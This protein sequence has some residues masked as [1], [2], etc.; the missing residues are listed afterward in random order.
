MK[1]NMNTYKGWEL[2]D[3]DR[4]TWAKQH[5][6]G[7][8]SFIG[9]MEISD[10]NDFVVQK[11]EY[12]ASDELEQDQW[13]VFMAVWEEGYGLIPYDYIDKEEWL[14]SLEVR[15]SDNIEL[16]IDKCLFWQ[17]FDNEDVCTIHGWEKACA[18]IKG[19]LDTY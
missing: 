6:D 9:L 7:H 19:L 18:K 5:E 15:C 13:G 11:G 17:D 14:N 8:Y 1:E 16:T 10:N 4:F 3:E 2:I 12:D